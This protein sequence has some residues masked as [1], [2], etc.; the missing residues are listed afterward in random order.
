MA[1]KRKA[2]QLAVSWLHPYAAFRLYECAA[3]PA[4]VPDLQALVTGIALELTSNWPNTI[5]IV[6]ESALPT[7]ANTSGWAVHFKKTIQVG[8][9]SDPAVV[10]V[11][12]HVLVLVC[13]GRVLG[14]STSAS[15]VRGRVNDFLESQPGLTAMA[16]DVLENALL[17]S[18]QLR[19]LWL[20]G[21]HRKSLFKADS[22]VLTG[23]QLQT[24]LNPLDDRTFRPSSGRALT[25]LSVS[26]G[27]SKVGVS[28]RKS[29][30]WIGPTIDIGD[31]ISRFDALVGHITQRRTQAFSPLPILA[32]AL[33][34]A[35]TAGA[36]IDAFDFAFI[37]VETA[38]DLDKATRV[39]L[40][41]F[42]ARV[43][44]V[45]AGRAG[46]QNFSLKIHDRD[47]PNVSSAQHD[48]DVE[49]TVTLADAT[50]SAV[51]GSGSQG[52]PRWDQFEKL[53]S[54]RSTWTVWYESGHSL[55]GGEW[56][57]LDARASS[58][59]GVITPIDFTGG[60]WDIESEKP[61]L[62]KA[63]DWSQIGIDKSLFSWWIKDGLASCFPDFESATDPSS[64]AFAVCD[65]GKDELADFVVMA[66]HKCFATPTNP[67]HLAFLMVH[68]KSS[69]S[70]DSGRGMAPKQYEEVLGQ[71]T[72]NLGRV[73]FPNVIT[74]L[75]GRLERGVAMLWEWKAGQFQVSL[76]RGKKL[77]ATAPLYSSLKVFDGRRSHLHVVVVQPHQG[78]KSFNAAMNASTIEFKTHMLCTLLCATDGAARAS[79][80]K[81]SIVMSP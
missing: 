35:P 11:E 30:A 25:G 26:T 14:M 8:W 39:M 69:S 70:S 63:V 81:L 57:M 2:I 41:E 48:W 50:A 5:A 47:H 18:A 54:N 24:A 67:S 59:E 37:A 16:P 51:L 58:Y 80:A 68:L 73:Q 64:F 38:A 3:S 7:T 6:A 66:K 55:G 13:D 61:L 75:Q 74:Y 72:K 19:T 9:T 76:P 44:F 40:E 46:D 42:E 36:V 60:N 52:W 56:N 27:V 32:Q 29:Y 31:F 21:I 22:K 4:H 49:V 10:D 78:A 12:Q 71:A 33:I 34:Q 62:G 77:K 23:S 65:D 17:R 79:S 45:T 43:G 1:K 20:T 15:E 28:P 53:L